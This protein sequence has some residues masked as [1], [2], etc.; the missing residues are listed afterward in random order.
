MIRISPIAQGCRPAPLL[1]VVLDSGLRTAARFEVGSALRRMTSDF[2]TVAPTQRQRTLEAL[3][4]RGR[5]ASIEAASDKFAPEP[6]A[7]SAS[8]QKRRLFES[9]HEPAGGKWKFLRDLEAGAS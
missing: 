2:C 7:D 4:V 5:V 8:P 3:G 1:R 6:M 9:R